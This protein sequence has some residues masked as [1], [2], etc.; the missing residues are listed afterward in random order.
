[1]NASFSGVSRG[2]RGP[3][4]Q[5]VCTLLAMFTQVEPRTKEFNKCASFSGVARDTDQGVETYV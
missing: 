3:G 5:H 1:M 2:T 4:F